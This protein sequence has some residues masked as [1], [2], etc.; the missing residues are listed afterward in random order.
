MIG[1]LQLWLAPV[2]GAL[3]TLWAAL[4]ALAAEANAPLPRMLAARAPDQGA[5]TSLPRS[6]HVIHLTLLLA[7]GAMAAA[8]VA[9]WVR[10]AAEATPRFFLAVLL[11][12]LVGDLMPRVLAVLSPDLVQVAQGGATMTV[13]LFQPLLRAVAWADRGGRDLAA[14]RAIAVTQAQNR[15]MLQGVF[16][17]RDMTV[18]EVMTPRIDAVAVDVADSR[19]QVIETLRQSAHSRLMVCDGHLDAVAGV[20]YAKDFLPGAG[21]DDD[22]WHTRI[23]PAVFVP[24]AKNLA[25]QLRD[26]QRGPSHIVVVVD[27]FGGTAGLVTLEDVLEQIVGEIRDEYDTDEVA[28]IVEQEPGRWVVQGGVAL[29]ELEGA[30]AHEFGRE[31]VDTVGGLVLATLGRVPRVGERVDLGPFRLTVD[32]VVRRRVSRVVVEAAAPTPGEGSAPV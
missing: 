24:E 20:I 3:L 22:D 12:W 2:L 31:D 19:D 14:R 18:A 17:L 27:E 23:R 29:A 21:R 16:A 8:A 28:P 26:F 32:Q 7:A 4:V 5:T 30:L 25:G 6:L 15:E 11:V 9:W 13:R 10:P 1:A